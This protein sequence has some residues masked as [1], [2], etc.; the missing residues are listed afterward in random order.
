MVVFS[1]KNYCGAP[2][3]PTSAIFATISLDP[4]YFEVHIFS[5]PHDPPYMSKNAK[6]CY[7]E[8]FSESRGKNHPKVWVRREKF[9]IG[10][11]PKKIS[12]PTIYVGS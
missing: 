2:G 1:D 4:L 7:F 11:C 9:N 10:N 12:G 6:M 5:D 3:G 8:H